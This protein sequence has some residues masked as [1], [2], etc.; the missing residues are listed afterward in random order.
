MRT[1]SFPWPR[2]DVH[3]RVVEEWNAAKMPPF[4]LPSRPSRHAVASFET[5]PRSEGHWSRFKPCFWSSGA[6][7]SLEDDVGLKI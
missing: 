3:R 5:K 1:K 4:D 7:V 2:C 6:M